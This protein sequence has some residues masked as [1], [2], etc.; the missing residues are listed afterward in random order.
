MKDMYWMLDNEGEFDRVAVVW[1]TTTEVMD[2][3]KLVDVPRKYMTAIADSHVYAFNK[4]M[5]K[6]YG[7]SDALDHEANV[8][9]N[10]MVK[11]QIKFVLMGKH[12][13]ELCD[14]AIILLDGLV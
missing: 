4:A 12:G 13:I 8:R 2:D 11:E 14:T 1:P 7:P 6:M 3:G 9:F 10:T 5:L